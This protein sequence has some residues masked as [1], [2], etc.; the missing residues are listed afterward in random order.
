MSQARTALE[1]QFS[2]LRSIVDKIK[3][4][5]VQITEV[6][7]QIDLTPE[8]NP[9]SLKYWCQGLSFYGTR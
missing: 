4:V 3:G 9:F 2:I 1:Q 8:V 5:N 7:K 6:Q